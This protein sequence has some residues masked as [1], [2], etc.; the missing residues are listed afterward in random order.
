M[1]ENNV[2][3]RTQAQNVEYSPGSTSTVGLAESHYYQSLTLLVDYDVTPGTSAT[4]A[5]NGILDLIEDIEIRINGEKSPKSLSLFSQHVANWYRDAA[6]PIADPVDW[7]STSAQS[8]TVQAD[9]NFLVAPKMFASL[10]P[11]F[12]FSNLDLR[13][14][15]ANE[16]DI[17]DPISSLSASL[18]VE[19]RE[20]LRSSI[21]GGTPVETGFFKENERRYSLDAT[22]VN[23]VE[24]PVGNRYHSVLIQV[25]EDGSPDNELIE[26]VKIVENGVETHFDTTFSQLRASNFQDYNL[27]S[28]ADGVAVL[29]Y[30]L[31]ADLDDVIDTAGMDQ[32]DIELDTDGESPT[33][34]EVRVVTRE[35]V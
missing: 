27:E 15:W 30:G 29:N 8:G 22:G 14:K 24:L 17:A 5:E 13:I 25:I 32:F 21:N 2:I 34:A 11:S 18:S 12:R 6:Q 26:N 3:N 20:R 16:S 9:V 31:R 28:L 33:N 19:S 35:L 7:G 10:L 1:S 4:P 23:T